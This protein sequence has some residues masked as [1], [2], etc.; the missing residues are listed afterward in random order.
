MLYDG[1]IADERTLESAAPHELALLNWDCL[2]DNVVAITAA[3]AAAGVA[4]V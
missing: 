4:V 3:G 1:V 2:W